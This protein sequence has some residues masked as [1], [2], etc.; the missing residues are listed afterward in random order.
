M[1]IENL[2]PSA[3]SMVLILSEHAL[4]TENGINI[5]KD[6][7]LLMNALKY[8]FKPGT[9]RIQM[10]KCQAHIAVFDPFIF[11]ICY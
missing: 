6:I 3:A 5:E 10:K 9:I 11:W 4:L 8:S 1:N 7:N 2:S